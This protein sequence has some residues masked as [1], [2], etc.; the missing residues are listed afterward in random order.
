[1]NTRF[2]SNRPNAIA[3][4][5][6]FPAAAALAAFAAVLWMSAMTADAAVK[7]Q[8]VVSPG[9]IE[10]WLVES[11]QVPLIAMQ[12]GFT[13]GAAQDPDGKEG[14]SYFVSGMLNEG[15][16]D[17][18]A[19]AFQERE[20]DLAVKMKFDATRDA[21]TGSFQ[22]LTK[23]RDEAFE[24]LR[25]ALNEPRFDEDA[26]GRIGAQ[27]ATGLKFDLNDP[28]KVAS[29]EWFRLAFDG[30]PYS[31]PLKGD[32]NSVKS[33]T[34]ADLK[35]YARRVFARDTLKV[36]VVGDI[37]A[38]TLG[39]V[40]DRVFGGLPEKSDL[41]K[42]AEV[43]PVE[44]PVRKVVEMNVPQSVAQFGMLGIKRND[45]DFI[46]SYILNYILG[47]G[48]FNSRLMEEVREKRGLAYSVYSYLSPY[49]HSA[50]YVGNVATENKSVGQSLEVIKAELKRMAEDGPTGEELDNAKQ[51]LTGSYPLRF[52][53][54]SKIASQLLWVQIEDLGIDYFDKR[55]GLIEAV[56]LDDVKR[57]ARRLL[58]SGGL[59]VTIVGKPT[60]LEAPRAAQPKPDKG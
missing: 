20:E 42:V 47:G 21:F 13:G 29:R 44:G 4:R 41:R 48:G 2:A 25:L 34:S 15:A 53:T 57:V 38:K 54:S 1:M 16:G 60:A 36:A 51:Y 11:R 27:I 23:N 37:D 58:A 45:D 6:R 43:K 33:I 49:K 3:A 32:A 52:D 22:T 55:N 9:G 31:N 5:L 39:G 26:V 59:I 17:L 14:L 7:I 56:T 8:R 24:L 30:H 18:D 46:P 50:V 40:L 35:D 12:Y 28:R 10:A 19:T